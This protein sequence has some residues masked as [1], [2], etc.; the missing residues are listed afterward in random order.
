MLG[1]ELRAVHQ[2]PTHAS[3]AGPEKWMG[4][5]RSERHFVLFDKL[6]A[7]GYEKT[8]QT[9]LQKGAGITKSRFESSE[10]DTEPFPNFPQGSD[11][12]STA[13]TELVG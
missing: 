7:S 6:V 2:G 9:R 4:A 8:I 13:K 5:E 12:T 11:D 10:V 3:S 1:P